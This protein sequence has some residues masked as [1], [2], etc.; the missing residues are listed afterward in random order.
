MTR[1]AAP[2]NVFRALRP[3]LATSVLL[4]LGACADMGN[5]H[6]QAKLMDAN[7]LGGGADILASTEAIDWPTQQWWTA[8]NDPQLDRLLA[9]AL[10]DSPT[11]RVAAA[12]VRQASSIAGVAEEATQPK[13][14]LHAVTNREHYSEDGTTPPPLNG[15]WAWRNQATVSAAYDLDLW[16]KNRDALA[17]AVDDIH[18]TSA[19]LQVARLTLQTAIL[20]N[21]IQLSYQF[22][23]Q[24]SLRDSLALRRNI[25]DITRKRQRAGLATEFDVTLLETALPASERALEQSDEAIALLRNQLAAL[26]GAG[27]AA[28]KS[29]TRPTLVLERVPGLPSALPAELVARRPDLAAQRWR[30]EAAAKRINVAKADFYPNINLS[31][32]AG[33]ESF[34]FDSFLDPRSRILGIAPAISL[35][36]FA[37]ARLRGQLGAQTA[38]YDGAVEQYNATLVQSLSEVANAVVT[39]RSLQRQNQLTGVSLASAKKSRALAEKAYRSGYTDAL[40]ALSAQVTLLG[41]QQ[42]MA[43][44]V[45]RQLDGYVSLMSA[46]GGGVGTQAEPQGGP[47][48]IAQAKATTT[49]ARPS[50]APSNTAQR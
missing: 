6:P 15:T 29:I 11:L 44:I 25:L 5:I 34:G 21:Y 50:A 43:L 40:N 48:E 18:F 42:Q 41:E 12:R 24:D 36:I 1:P 27:P 30:V 9:S 20:R 46:L 33:L 37:G 39:V 2:A 19:E 45:A 23:L 49:P 17:A 31:A 28:G 38:I 32:Y 35:P 16:G 10:A 7:Q 14:E 13:A 3:L 4:V 47:E 26:T 8:L 22:A